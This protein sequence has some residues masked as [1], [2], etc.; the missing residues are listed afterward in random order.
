MLSFV[1]KLSELKDSL[2]IDISQTHREKYHIMV[3]HI[4]K[5]K[6]VRLYNT[7]MLGKGQEGNMRLVEGY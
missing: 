4:Q 1:G 7:K 2:L 5:P 6:G 3:A